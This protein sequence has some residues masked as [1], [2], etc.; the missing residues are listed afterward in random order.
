MMSQHEKKLVPQ[1]LTLLNYND[2]KYSMNKYNW[3]L[4]EVHKLYFMMNK[5]NDVNNFKVPRRV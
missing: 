5:N 2:K 1:S 3:N 4:E